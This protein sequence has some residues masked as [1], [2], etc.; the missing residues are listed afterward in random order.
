LLSVS[1]LSAH[2]ISVGNLTTGGTGKTPLVEFVARSL[3]RQNRRV[4]VLTR[5]YR[6]DNPN[7]QILVSDG[8]RILSGVGAAGDEPMLLARNLLGSAAVICN[9]DRYD[10][11]VWASG[12]L[13]CDTFVLDDGFQHLQLARDFNI[14]VVDATQAWESAHLLP[15]G[16]LRESRK[17]V[18]RAECVIITRTDQGE[19]GSDLQKEIKRLAPDTPVFTS[20]M[21]VRGF[22]NLK[23]YSTENELPPVA[24]TQVPQRLAAFCGIANPTSFFKLL[25]RANCQ[26]SQTTIFPDHHRYTQ[27]DVS[28][29]VAEAQNAGLEYLVTTAKDAVKL[30][31]LSVELPCYV[32]E[33]EVSI[34]DEQGFLELLNAS[35]PG[36]TSGKT[37][38]KMR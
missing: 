24:V 2:V 12:N 38:Q 6:R 30:Q 20:R 9:A 27:T 13:G 17:A 33:I 25:E 32:M 11:G 5:G 19:T 26:T 23:D 15:W 14:L 29:I 3:A 36:F 35:L 16:N 7:R 1:K 37:D 34:D 28:R 31:S 18:S 22:Q 21:T 8:G 10:A 4:C